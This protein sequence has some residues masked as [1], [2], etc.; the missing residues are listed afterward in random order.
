MFDNSLR[1][2]CDMF[3]VAIVS[4][5]DVDTNQINHVLLRE[6]WERTLYIR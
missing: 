6:K 3:G 1:L 2:F 5:N 4:N